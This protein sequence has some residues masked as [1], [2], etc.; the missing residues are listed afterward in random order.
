M[1]AHLQSWDDKGQEIE[2]SDGR[3]GSVEL[4]LRGR[5]MKQQKQ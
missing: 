3:N 1:C 4:G 2:E 5:E